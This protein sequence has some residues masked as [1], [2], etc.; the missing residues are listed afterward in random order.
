MIADRDGCDQQ[1]GSDTKN[2]EM[3]WKWDH[4]RPLAC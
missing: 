3:K 4:S 2:P 1:D